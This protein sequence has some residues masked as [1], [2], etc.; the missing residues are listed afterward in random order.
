MECQ[1]VTSKDIIVS[2]Y[3][4]FVLMIIVP[5]HVYYVDLASMSHIGNIKLESLTKLL[6]HLTD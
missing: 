6:N 2:A 1:A 3:N 5:H 4:I